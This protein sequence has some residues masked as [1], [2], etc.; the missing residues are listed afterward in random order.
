MS[1]MYT[2]NKTGSE[3]REGVNLAYKNT[4]YLGEME[5]VG[6]IAHSYVKLKLAK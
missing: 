1:P 3:A 6:F 2:F 5:W 4:G